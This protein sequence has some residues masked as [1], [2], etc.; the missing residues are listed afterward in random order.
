MLVETLFDATGSRLYNSLDILS[1]PNCKLE[2]KAE[3][4]DV[5]DCKKRPDEGEELEEEAVHSCDS[6]LQVFESLSDIT[7]HKINQCQL[8]VSCCPLPQS[9]LSAL[10][11]Q[12]ECTDQCLRSCVKK[13]KKSSAQELFIFLNEL[14]MPGPSL[15]H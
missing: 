7:E 9:V 13:L 2:D 11:L 3:D 8:T 4:G 5:L 10:K 6:C 1:D 14:V 12:A 15:L